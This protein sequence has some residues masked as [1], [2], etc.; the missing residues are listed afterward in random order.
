M[1][2]NEEAKCFQLLTRTN[3]IPTQESYTLYQLHNG[4][5]FEVELNR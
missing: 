5:A 4:I 3:S 2:G 1:D